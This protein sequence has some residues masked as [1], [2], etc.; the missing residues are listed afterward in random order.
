MNYRLNM[1][2]VIQRRIYIAFILSIRLT[3]KF[4]KHRLENLLGCCLGHIMPHYYRSK[5][6]KLVTGMRKK[7]QNRLGVSVLCRETFLLS[8]ITV[9]SRHRKKSL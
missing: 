3:L 1:E 7:L 5:T 2:K 8:I 4:S 9:S 6:L